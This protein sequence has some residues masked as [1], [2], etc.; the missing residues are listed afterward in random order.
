MT[1]RTVMAAWLGPASMRDGARSVYICVPV[2]VALAGRLDD[3]LATIV[4]PADRV[5]FASDFADADTD[6]VAEYAAAHGNES[7]SIRD[8]QEAPDLVVV[9]LDPFADSASSLQATALLPRGP[10]DLVLAELP[11]PIR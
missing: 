4:R 11:D 3:T 8:E 9:I 1:K 7:R 2:G 6:P 5:L 10:F